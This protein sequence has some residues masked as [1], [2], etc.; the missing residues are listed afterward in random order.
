MAPYSVVASVLAAA[1]PQQSGSVRQLPSTIN[2]AITQRSQSRH[3]ASA[4]SASS[5]TTM[6]EERDN[7]WEIGGPYWWPFSSF[8][9]PAHLD[10]SLPGDRGF[11]P[12]SLGTSWGQPPVDV[13]DPNYDESRLRWLLEGELYNGR[14]AMLAVVGVLTVE[15][16]G[17]GPWWEIPGNLNLFGTPYVVAVVGGHLAFALLEKKRLEN[18]RETGEAGHFGAA[19]F[20][21]LDLTEANPLGTDYNRQAEVRNCRLAMLTFLGFS[22]QAW[23]TGKGPIENAKDH[24]ASPF[25]A[26]IFTYGD[27]GTNVVAIFSAFAAVMHIA[28]L[29]REKKAEDKP[30]SRNRTLS[31][32]S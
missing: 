9:P 6:L 4:S 25:E 17:K 3:V 30:R 19:R 22:V 27:R 10:G 26:N 16:Q 5:P 31:G 8:T 20:D 14:L 24:L 23:V 32:S 15:A 13:S 12:F 21:P 2:R 29:A 7:L 18:F 28:E 1:P 11:D